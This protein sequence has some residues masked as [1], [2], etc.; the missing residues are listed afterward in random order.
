MQGR[1]IEVIWARAVLLHF[2]PPLFHLL[3][4]AVYKKEIAA[5][6]SGRTSPLLKF[7]SAVGGYLAMGLTWEQVCVLCAGVHGCVQ[8]IQSGQQ[9]RA[10]PQT[11][12]HRH[13]P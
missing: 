12:A 9:T 13:Q 5:A 2:G 8:C 11:L 10:Q 3:Y 1:P 6:Y 7:W 4:L